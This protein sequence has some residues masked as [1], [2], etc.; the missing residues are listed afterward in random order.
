[1]YNHGITS[2]IVFIL[3]IKQKLWLNSKHV[4][5]L[6]Q[7]QRKKLVFQNVIHIIHVSI[8]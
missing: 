6:N 3:E 7:N 4:I 2:I 1:M 8:E 5:T